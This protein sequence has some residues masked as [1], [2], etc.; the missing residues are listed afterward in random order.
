ML[1]PSLVNRK[2][3]TEESRHEG[4]WIAADD[5]Y[6]EKAATSY[7]RKTK[8]QGKQRLCQQS[9]DSKLRAPDNRLRLD[10]AMAV[11]VTIESQ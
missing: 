3:T 6:A 8:S 2:V 10:K 1:S 9:L 5:T 11:A 4:S 7:P